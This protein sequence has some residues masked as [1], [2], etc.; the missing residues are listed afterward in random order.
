[1]DAIT[2]PGEI[3]KDSPKPNVS[4]VR[5][6]LDVLVSFRNHPF[7]LYE[8]ERME[9]MVESIRQND[10][11]VPIVVRTLDDGK[12]EILSGHNRVAASRKLGLEYISAV[13][14]T[15]LSDELA[16]LYVTESNLVQR[17]FADLKHSERAIALKSHLE[18][19]KKISGQG[20]RH[21]LFEYLENETCAQ[22]AH[23][24]KSRDKVAERHALSKDTVMRYVRI[25][26]LPRGI[27]DKLDD[28]TVKFTVAVEL[29]WLKEN[30]LSVLSGL[31]DEGVKISGKI[32]GEL[33]AASKSTVKDLG[34]SEIMIAI[35]RC[36]AVKRDRKVSLS[37]EILGRLDAYNI[38]TEKAVADIIAL[39]FDLLD[40][41]IVEGIA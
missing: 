35:K 6:K 21:D 19:L 12:Y 3:T 39:Y 17:S 9:A 13:I 27:L 33:R 18:S 24:L 37:N 31:I 5:L 1:V 41:G 7:A 2:L 10:V 26:K 23:K 22:V 20:K 15:D 29:S 36:T 28:G 4:Y 40:K 30:E 14:Y 8:G 34:K 32:A 16:S 38:D 11:I 25:A